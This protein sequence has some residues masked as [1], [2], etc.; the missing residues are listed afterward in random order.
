MS[1]TRGHT[2][3]RHYKGRF[4]ECPREPVYPRLLD[5]ADYDEYK[6]VVLADASQLDYTLDH[7]PAAHEMWGT[8][9]RRPHRGA[10][11]R[12]WDKWY[13]E[14]S[15]FLAMF[16]DSNKR[17]DAATSKVVL[18]MSPELVGRIASAAA[19]RWKQLKL[20]LAAA[21]EPI[22]TPYPGYRNK[23]VVGRPPWD[24][25]KDAPEPG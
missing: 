19:E 8:H 15:A 21:P 17:Y 22:D 14:D 5:P 24:N 11:K 20:K 6:D 1:R 10:K 12:L 18:P 25:T 2:R 13:K 4:S 23:D 16:S 3:P 9:H 7:V